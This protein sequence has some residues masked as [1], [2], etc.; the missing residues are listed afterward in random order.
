[1]GW[2]LYILYYFIS[3]LRVKSDKKVYESAYSHV[4]IVPIFHQLNNDSSLATGNSENE[5][6]SAL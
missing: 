1:M 3:D 5:T 4:Q 2:I 6:R